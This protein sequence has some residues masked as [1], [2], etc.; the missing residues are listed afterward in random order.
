MFVSVNEIIFTLIPILLVILIFFT[1]ERPWLGIV[2]SLTLILGC[3]PITELLCAL[4]G[5]SRNG[6]IMLIPLFQAMGGFGLILSL[7][8]R[9]LP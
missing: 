2:V 5:M 8:K 4:G 6:M 9:T 1:M 7:K 3:T